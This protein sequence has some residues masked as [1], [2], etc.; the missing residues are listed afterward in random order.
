[1]KFLKTLLVFTLV[2]CSFFHSYSATFDPFYPR[3]IQSEGVY[4]VMVQYDRGG[5]TK[6]GVTLV[7]YDKWCN[8]TKIILIHCDKDHNGIINAND[9]RLVTLNDV[10]PI[11]Q[12]RYWDFYRLSEIHNQAVAEM[13]SDMIINCGTGTN[14]RHIKAIQKY[15]GVEQDGIIGTK[16]LAKINKAN[17]SKLYNYIYTYREQYYR[18]IGVGTQTKFLAGWLNRIIKLK[19]LHHNE[20]Y[21][22]S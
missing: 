9:L 12:K 10:K 5:A 17:Q 6:F 4:F 2:W 8:A 19:K 7:V 1:M 13:I 20:K 22:I 11:Y 3:L 15:L 16:M 14:H 21:L 18:K